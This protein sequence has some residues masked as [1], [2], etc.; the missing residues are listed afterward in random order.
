MRRTGRTRL[1]EKALG[2]PYEVR[3]AV[4]GHAKG[5]LDRVYDQYDF[6]EEKREAL[7]AWSERLQRIVA[8]DEGAKSA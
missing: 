1:S 2:V 5:E 4:I 7:D 6:L 3:E 8:P